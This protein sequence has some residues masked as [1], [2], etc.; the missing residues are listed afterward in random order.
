LDDRRQTGEGIVRDPA[1]S[2]RVGA[3][4]RGVINDLKRNT[5][6]AAAELGV[7][8]EVIARIIAGETGVPPEVLRRAVE[9][10]P[11]NER[12]FFP[13]HDDA[14]DGVLV[15]GAGESAKSSRVFQRGGVDYYEY[16]DTAMSRLA[17][18]RPEWIKMLQAVPDDDPDNPAVRWNKGHFLYQFTYFVGDVNYYYEWQGR[19]H[20]VAMSTGDSVS[21]LPYAPHSFAYREGGSGLILALTYGGRLLGDAQHELGALGGDLAEG[22]AVA[23]ADERAASAAILRERLDDTLHPVTRLAAVS[24]VPVPRLDALLAGADLPT[25][26]ELVALAGALRVSVRDLLPVVGD[27][28]DGVCVVRR[29]AAPTWRWPTDDA[30][31]YE[32]RSLAGTRLCPD[33][34]ALELTVLGRDPV[35]ATVRTGLHQ[36]CFVLGPD[37]VRLRWQHDGEPR[38]RILEPDD[39]LYV[40][41]FVPHGFTQVDSGRSTVLALRIGGKV[42]G[43][44]RREAAALGAPALRRLVLDAGQWYD[45]AGGSR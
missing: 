42:S 34:R 40:K 43:D 45:A 23:A 10:W 19:R 6:A 22:Y 36:Y 7:A 37:P 15:M 27:E 31:A 33:S 8:P 20:C 24:G 13:I 9:V 41:P 5:E 32:V 11:V 38:E 12:D 14:P 30:P 16:R 3:T 28:R 18:F 39:S 4:F 25:P 17:M 21:G 29:D 2:Y 44:T 1:F 26:D 35:A